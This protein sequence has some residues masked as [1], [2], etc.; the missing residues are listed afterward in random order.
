MISLSVVHVYMFCFFFR[1]PTLLLLLLSSL[2]L[3]TTLKC[4]MYVNITFECLTVL[5]Q[6]PVEVEANVCLETLWETL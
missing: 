1:L 2:Y 6:R 3:L 4:F 5:K